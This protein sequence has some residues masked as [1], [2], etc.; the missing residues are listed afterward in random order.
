[1]SSTSNLYIGGAAVMWRIA[2]STDRAIVLARLKEIG[3]ESYAPKERGDLGCLRAAVDAEYEPMNKQERYVI[4]SIKKPYKGY[5]VVREIPGEEKG[6][7]DDWGQVVATA[8][9]VNG[10]GYREAPHLRINPHSDMRF[11]SISKGMAGAKKW[12]TAN[13]VSAALT[14]IIERVCDGVALR[15]TGGVY[16]VRDVHLDRWQQIAR[17]F[18]DGS[19]RKDKDGKD[20]DP[21]AIYVLRVVADEQMVRA[22]GD[23]LSEEVCGFLDQIEYDIQ[24]ISSGEMGEEAMKN[25]I[26]RMAEMEGK[27]KRYEAAFSAPLPHLI[28]AVGHV[29][30]ALAV[31]TIEATAAAV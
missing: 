12:L 23:A 1:M 21:T 29:N 16:W 10:H 7:G 28:E 31:A 14:D 4:R 13:A 11:D 18:E 8:G 24:R 27:I 2:H 15:S 26:R 19:A 6:A 9:L 3:Y 5:A 22:V 30:Q 17:I 20:V 25:R